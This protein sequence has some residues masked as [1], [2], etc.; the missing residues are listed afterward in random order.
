MDK[1]NNFHML[2][3]LCENKCIRLLNTLNDTLI[4]LNNAPS[5]IT[6]KVAV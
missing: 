2:F 3:C 4:V 5:F 1:Y 6:T